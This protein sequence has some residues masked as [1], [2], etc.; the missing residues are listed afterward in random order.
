[1]DVRVPDDETAL[2]LIRAEVA[3]LPSSGAAFYRHG[4]DPAEPFQAA[5]EIDGLFP[6]DHRMT[7]AAEEVLARLVDQ[8]L[9]WEIFPDR[10]REMIVGIGRV[11]GLYMGFVINRQGLIDDVEHR[12]AKK[13]AGILYKEGIAKVAAFSRACAADGIPIVWLQ[14]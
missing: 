12:G 2:A 4:A 7:Y 3:K 14:D 9:F 1:A 6:S 8:S 13:P 11:S 5:H 10:G